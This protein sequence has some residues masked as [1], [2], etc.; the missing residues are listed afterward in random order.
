[1]G[2]LLKELFEKYAKRLLTNKVRPSISEEGIMTIPNKQ[3]VEK[4]AQNLYED[5]KKAGVPD[6]ILKTENDIKVFH[7]KIAEINNENMVKQFDTLMSESTL[8]NPKKSAD[9]F[10]LKGNKIKNPDNI[11]GGE[12]IIETEADILTRLNKGNKESLS[13]IRYENAVKAEEAKAAADEDYIMKVLDP[14]DFS[15]GGRAGYYGGGQAMV[16]P[17]LSDIGHGSDALMGRTRLTAPGSQATTSTGLNYLLGEDNDNVRVPFNEGL[18]VPPKKP[19]TKEMFQDDSMTLLQGMHGTGKDSN[20]FLYNEMIKKGNI[21]RKQGVERETVI[22]IIKNNKD[23]IDMILKQ[24]IGDKKSLAGLADGGR[25]GYNKGKIAKKVVNEGRRGFMKAAGAAGAGI[26]AL[27]TGLLGFGK[28]VIAPATQAANEAAGK[29][30]KGVPPYFLKLV[31]KIKNFGTDV[32][33]TGALAERQNVKQYKDFTLTEDTATGRIEIQKVKNAPGEEFGK[34]NF[35]NGLTEEVYMGYTPPETIV[36]KG[37][38]IKTKPEYDE[39]TAYLRND[40]PQTGEVYEEVSGVTDE[41]L[42][43][44]GEAVVKKADGGRIGFG[45]GDI[46]TKGGPA[47]IKAGEGTFTKA[48]YLIERI[49]NTIKGNPKDK[50]IQDT[51]PGF[52]KELEV[53]PELAKNEN[54]FKE[55]GGDL[56]EDQKI[57]VYSDDTL[58]FFTT[59][60]G[61]QNIQKVE[62]F[63]TKHGLSREKALEVMKMEPNDQVMELTKTKFIKNRQTDN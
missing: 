2:Q 31:E 24:Q 27:K 56:P 48:Q 61:P 33:E 20:E 45:K 52:I 12:E 34:D 6:N 21:L 10:D 19:Y 42:K 35:G 53:N 46:V 62:K 50:Y 36:V 15:K 58:D 51:F 9:V 4:M 38:S 13:N 47:L 63:M 40:G 49:K 55:L 22:E 44:V 16:E 14:E 11:M 17:D 37:K 5:F 8:F 59:S 28:S 60:S 7:H 3:R 32:T 30:F 29:A 39:G 26:A 41:V 1:M 43:E 18:L 25:I 23:K 57:V 54:V